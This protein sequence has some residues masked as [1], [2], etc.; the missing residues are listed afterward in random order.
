[1]HHASDVRAERLVAP[2]HG[3]N[4]LVA[5]HQTVVAH[6]PVGGAEN[7]FQQ[8]RVQIGAIRHMLIQNFLRVIGQQYLSDVEDNGIHRVPRH[9][10]VNIIKS[11]EHMIHLI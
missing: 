4:R 11:A 2:D 6:E 5:G 10:F 9:G 7:L 3:I 8:N 1:M